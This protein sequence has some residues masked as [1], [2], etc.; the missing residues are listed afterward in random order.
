MYK[1]PAMNKRIVG[2]QAIK[3]DLICTF[4]YFYEHKYLTF[5]GY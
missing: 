3:K 5:G 4:Q 1:Q 2:G